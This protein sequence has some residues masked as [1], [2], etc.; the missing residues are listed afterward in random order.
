MATTETKKKQ[1][2]GVQNVGAKKAADF[3][4][5]SKLTGP[6]AD[7]SFER[8]SLLFA[9]VS[10]ISYMSVEECNVAAGK[11]GFT[12]GKFFDT[13]NAQAYW[14]HNEWDLSLIHI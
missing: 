8:K 9:E 10:M 13:E 12:N 3:V 6:I 11:I 7:L 4:F 5:K 14:F 2:K 1:D